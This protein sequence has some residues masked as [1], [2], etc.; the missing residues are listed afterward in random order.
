MSARAMEMAYVAAK[1]E[2]RIGR[3]SSIET[4]RMGRSMSSWIETAKSSSR[5][6]HS[7][8]VVHLEVEHGLTHSYANLVASAAREQVAAGS[9]TDPDQVASPAVRQERRRPIHEALATYVFDPRF[10]PPKFR[11][12]P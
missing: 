12:R 7:E 4:A 2:Q 9:V 10:L 11:R 3:S 1:L 6:K 5:V 8:I